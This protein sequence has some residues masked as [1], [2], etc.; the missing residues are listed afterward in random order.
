MYREL[1]PWWPLLAPVDEHEAEAAYVATVLHSA[2]IGVRDVLHLG[3]AAGRTAAHLRDH[4]AMTLVDRCP[5][6]LG[7]SSRLNP[8]CR[9]VEGDMRTLRL[10][11]RFDAVLALDAVD[12]L[13]TEADLRATVATAHAHCRPGGIAVFRPRQV[14]ET[15]AQVSRCGGTDGADGRSARFHSWTWDPDPTD[16]WALTS[17][18]YVLRTADGALHLS[19][20]TRRTGLFGRDVWLDALAEAG[21]EAN[22]LE[23]DADDDGPARTI[24]LGHRPRS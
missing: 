4:F 7:V 20:Q 2:R 11:D 5:E 6:M 8:Q 10:D 9:H 14:H 3:S 19:Q 17:Y 24:L 16:T 23:E 1:A 13:T 22:A 21:F 12:H 18:A 15:F